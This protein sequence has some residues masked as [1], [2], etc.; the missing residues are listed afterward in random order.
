MLQI[1][2][3]VILRATLQLYR[4]EKLSEP[5]KDEIVWG[6]NNTEVK[7]K[8]VFCLIPWLM[9][10][11]PLVLIAGIYLGLAVCQGHCPTSLTMT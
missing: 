7:C 11:L 9:V 6:K 3:D 8:P 2:D 5:Q 4:L 10:F 1:G